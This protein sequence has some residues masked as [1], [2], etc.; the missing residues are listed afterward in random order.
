LLKPEP[1]PVGVSV[2]PLGEGRAPI[3]LPEGF[4]VGFRL[5][6]LVVAPVAGGPAVL[7]V[8]IPF[9][10][11]LD[12]GPLAAG[13][14]LLVP[15]AEP[16]LPTCARANVLDSASAPANAMVISFMVASFPDQS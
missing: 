15:P 5:L 4:M 8:V 12:V 14:A 3:V 16:P 11:E 10:D 6:L 13:P 2:D 9:I 7:P 1:G